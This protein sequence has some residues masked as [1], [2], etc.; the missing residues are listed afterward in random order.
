MYSSHTVL[1]LLH[2][3]CKQADDE[4]VGVV[5]VVGSSFLHQQTHDV[6]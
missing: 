1:D 6:N 5:G 2:D 4:D 3:Q